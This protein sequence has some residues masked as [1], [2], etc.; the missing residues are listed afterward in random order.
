MSQLFQ[1]KPL[2]SS[3]VVDVKYDIDGTRGDDKVIFTNTLTG[4]RGELL[5][6]REYMEILTGKQYE[7]VCLAV[8]RPDEHSEV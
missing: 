7:F 1:N 6:I 3:I 5:G 4:L 8:D 2:L